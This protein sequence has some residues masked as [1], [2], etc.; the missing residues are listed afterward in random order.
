MNGD[1]SKIDYIKKENRVSDI[2]Q[3]QLLAMNRELRD[4]WL[5]DPNYTYDDYREIFDK[6]LAEFSVPD[7]TLFVADVA[8]GTLVLW[9]DAPHSDN[10][11]VVVHFHSG[12]YLLGSTSGYRS[13]GGFLSAATGARVL[14]VDYR[15]APEHAYPAAIEDALSAYQWLL[16]AGYEPGKITISGDSA[17]GGLALVALQKIR[18]LGLPLPGCGLAISPLADF[19]ASGPSRTENM[20]TD[21]LVTTELLEAMAAT[22]CGDRDRT[23]PGLSPL[24]GNWASIPPLLILAGG[25]EAMRDDG[26]LCGEAAVRAGVDATYIEGKDMVHIWPVYADRLPQAREALVEIGNFVRRHTKGF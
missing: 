11:R 1:A 23:D 24:F 18:D 10:T 26:K 15:L 20:A 12:G 8:N 3:E 4:A 13:F 16:A 14:L 7:G 25:I 5:A 2:N 19:T 17:G 9:A 22:Y 21:P 6:W